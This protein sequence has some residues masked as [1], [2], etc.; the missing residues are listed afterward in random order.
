MTPGSSSITSY[1]GFLAMAVGMFLA[2]LDIQIV[3]SS[4]IE[5]QA[6]LAIPPTRLSYLQTIYLIAEII[7]IAATGR[8]AR[9]L[10]TR[11]L[12]TLGLVG[13]VLA[14]AAC[15][16]STSYQ[17]LYAARAVQGFFGG[18]LIPTVF[19]AVFLMF[20]L[21]RQAVATAIAGTFAMLAPTL[22][23]FVG[24]WITEHLSWHWLFLINVAPGLIAAAVVAA[25]VRIDTPDGKSLRATDMA[26]LALAVVFLAGLE[27]TLKEAPGRGWLSGASLSLLTVTLASGVLLVRRCLKVPEPLIEVRAFRDLDFAIGAW[28]SFVLGMALFG[29]VYLMPLFL[30]HVRGHGSLAI[31]TIMMVTGAAQLITAP[32]A[33]FLERRWAAKP[34]TAAGFALFAAGLIMNGFAAPAWDFEELFAP[35]LLR[36][37][38]L[39]F[40]LLPITRLA[41]GH[42]SSHDVP[43]ASSLFN[44]MRNV[45]GAVGLALIDTIVETRTADHAAAIVAKLEAGDRD[46]AAFV[47][48]PLERFTGEPLGPMDEYTQSLA[49]PMVE[50]AAATMSFN[51]AWLLLGALVGLSLLALPWVGREKRIAPLKG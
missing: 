34:M 23:P 16:A 24:G 7:A 47:G 38:A 6:D 32:L 15:A 44:L 48:L 4:L 27:L 50:R 37:V 9:A 10:S 3:A 12:F 51:E 19:S 8:L 11:W 2:I 26:S 21:E 39:L 36:G 49:A 22:G 40:C 46:M 25:W 1:A 18:V 43:Q 5:I 28:F 13:F 30:G 20:P 31:G 14:S 45:G 35:Q 41:L 33:A 17:M 29:A 42:L